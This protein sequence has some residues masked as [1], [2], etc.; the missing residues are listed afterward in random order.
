MFFLMIR[1]PPRSTRTDTLLPYTTLFRSA[2]PA[3]DRRWRPRRRAR[4]AGQQ[5][6]RRPLH[7]SEGRSGLRPSGHHML[8]TS[9]LRRGSADGDRLGLVLARATLGPAHR[10]RRLAVLPDRIAP[11]NVD[12][13]VLDQPL[14]PRV[15]PVA[16]F[17]G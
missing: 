2:I 9:G 15:P 4:M 17:W 16:V 11:R 5:Q 12:G 13:L 14:G 3:R 7:K 10:R 8:R 1:R 6:H